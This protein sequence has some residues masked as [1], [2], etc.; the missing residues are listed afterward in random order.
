MQKRLFDLLSDIQCT[1]E[2]C[3]AV[4]G[5]KCSSLARLDRCE[6][7]AITRHLLK[8]GVIAPPCKVGTTIYMI[9]TKRAK[10][11]REY[12]SFIKKTKLTYLNMERV[13]EEFG[14][15]VFLSQAE[16]EEKMEERN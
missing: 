16:A 6:I 4:D 3:S 12:F 14:E 8:N 7:E 13:L 2:S 15:T 5:G 11:S 1:A 10:V 9:V